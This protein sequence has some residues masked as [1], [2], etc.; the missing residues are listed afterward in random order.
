MT[1]QQ[2]KQTYLIAFWSPVPSVIAAGMLATW[3]FGLT[4]ALWAVTGEF[5]R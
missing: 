5:T 3:Y 4:G 2:F 1:W